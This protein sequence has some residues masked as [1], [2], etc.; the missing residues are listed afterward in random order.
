MQTARKEGESNSARFHRNKCGPESLGHEGRASY[1]IKLVDL[2]T[3]RDRSL[4]PVV[5]ESV[6][7]VPWTLSWMK[8]ERRDLCVGDCDLLALRHLCAGFYRL[9]GRCSCR[10]AFAAKIGSAG[11]SLSQESTRMEESRFSGRDTIPLRVA[12]DSQPTFSSACQGRIR[13]AKKSQ[14]RSK[15]S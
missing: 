3:N 13:V 10:A 15:N 5:L 7:N 14:N 6:Q 4:G 12:M 1:V 8:A 2:K 9:G 11:A